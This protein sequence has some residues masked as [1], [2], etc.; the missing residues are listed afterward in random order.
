MSK[1]AHSEIVK[2]IFYESYKQNGI[3]WKGNVK[4][5]HQ[6]EP[7]SSRAPNL[8]FKRIALSV[9]AP[10]LQSNEFLN[11]SVKETDESEPGSFRTPT[12]WLS[13]WNRQGNGPVW[14]WE[15]Q[16]SKC[17]IFF[18]EALRKR[19]ALSLWTPELQSNYFLDAIVKETDS[20]R[21]GAP[22]LQMHYFLNGIVIQE[23]RNS[24]IH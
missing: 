9:G 12:A 24:G 3:Q 10:E 4:E 17:M 21:L 19:T 16:S 8:C 13:K 1:T 18:R 23:L 11:G 2:F 22:E 15:L 5:A 20:L 6:S 14:A 7:G